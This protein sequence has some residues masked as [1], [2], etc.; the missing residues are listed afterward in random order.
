MCFD[1]WNRVD[2]IIQL[3]DELLFMN[4]TVDEYDLSL[5]CLQYVLIIPHL[6]LFLKV[7]VSIKALTLT[8]E[9]MNPIT[10]IVTECAV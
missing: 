7:L 3:E 10:G 4:V 8:Y 6:I 1:D 9:L 5:C 2:F